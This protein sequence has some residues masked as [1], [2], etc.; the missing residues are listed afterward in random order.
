MSFQT[1]LLIIVLVLAA[2]SMYQL[3]QM[4]KALRPLKDL[5]IPRYPDPPPVPEKRYLLLVSE[6]QEGVQYWCVISDRPVDVYSIGKDKEDL[7]AATGQL[8]NANACDYEKWTFYDNHL[9]TTDIEL[10][11]REKAAREQRQQDLMRAVGLTGKE[12]YA[13]HLST[14]G[15]TTP[16]A[17]ADLNR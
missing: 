8:Y 4:R 3:R 10:A 5:G 16:G 13:S 11:P 12:E 1:L 15:D 2:E 6:L 7:P 17:Y 9:Y 14:N